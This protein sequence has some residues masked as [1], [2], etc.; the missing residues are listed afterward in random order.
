VAKFI[1]NELE[2]IMVEQGQPLAESREASLIAIADIVRSAP[3]LVEGLRR[4]M[5]EL[6]ESRTDL[7]EENDDEEELPPAERPSRVGIYRGIVDE[8][9][10]H[11]ATFAKLVNHPGLIP[12]L[13]QLMRWEIPEEIR[14]AA[15]ESVEEMSAADP[16]NRTLTTAMRGVVPADSAE[17][18]SIDDPHVIEAMIGAYR[19]S[20]D[21]VWLS[22]IDAVIDTVAMDPVLESADLLLD[23]IV[24]I[25]Q[26]AEGEQYLDTVRTIAAPSDGDAIEARFGPLLE[27][28]EAGVREV[29]VIALSA[30]EHTARRLGSR[31]APIALELMTQFHMA[32][33][34][35]SAV[36]ILL[37][38]S[39]SS[40]LVI[41][42]L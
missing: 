9:L 30:N 18:P 17:V 33:R 15:L 42:F 13:T 7:F 6:M 38:C 35:L 12:L 3:H 2:M 28:P 34:P 11:Y 25:C 41:F 14:A 20:G 39:P 32:G 31:L 22:A 8:H 24:S 19:D 10:F 4:R 36:E 37:V 23:G 21:P 29:A 27:S 40:S 26:T 16:I 1:L 5:A